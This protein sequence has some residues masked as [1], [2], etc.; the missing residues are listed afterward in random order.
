[1]IFLRSE[2]RR[3]GNLILVILMMKMASVAET[4]VQLWLLL[5]VGVHSQKKKLFFFKLEV[6]YC[7]LFQG[8]SGELI[9]EVTIFTRVC[10]DAGVPSYNFSPVPLIFISCEELLTFKTRYTV[11][12][13]PKN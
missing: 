6:F 10:K 4:G 5:V 8:A 9:N 11:G 12:R 13:N 2:S 1:M 7:F 3:P